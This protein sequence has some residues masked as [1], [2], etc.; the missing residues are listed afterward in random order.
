MA[1]TQRCVC[2]CVCVSAASCDEGSWKLPIH[3]RPSPAGTNVALLCRRVPAN[4]VTPRGAVNVSA[5]GGRPTAETRQAADVNISQHF[6]S[7]EWLPCHVTEW[8][9]D[10][11]KIK[12]RLFFIILV[13]F[14]TPAFFYGHVF[15]LEENSLS[16]HNRYIKY[17]KQV[18]KKKIHNNAVSTTLQQ[19]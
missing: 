2:V 6:F 14:L 5:C 7:F 12:T 10:S 16:F 4:L 8:R 9:Y 1:P 17:E 13:L 15:V 11:G 19:E 18:K 3:P